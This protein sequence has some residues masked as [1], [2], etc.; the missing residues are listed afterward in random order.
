MAEHFQNHVQEKHGIH[1]DSL[2][3]IWEFSSHEKELLLRNIKASNVY[4][5]KW[6]RPQATRANVTWA[7]GEVWGHFVPS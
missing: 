3:L 1:V 5:E 6:H 2:Y 7:K 4:V